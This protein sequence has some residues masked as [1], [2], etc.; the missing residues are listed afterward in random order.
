MKRNTKRKISISL[1]NIQPYFSVSF[2]IVIRTI[3]SVNFFVYYYKVFFSPS[4]SPVSVIYYSTLSFKTKHLKTNRLRTH[5][6]GRLQFLQSHRIRIFTREIQ[7]TLIPRIPSTSV[8]YV[9]YIQDLLIC[10][11]LFSIHNQIL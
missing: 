11:I 3:Q 9:I 2:T 8:I 10:K 6:S 5:S 1:Q 4:I 7:V